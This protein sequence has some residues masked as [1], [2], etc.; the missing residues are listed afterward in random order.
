M[1]RIRRLLDQSHTSISFASTAWPAAGLVVVMSGALFA[2]QQE[3]PRPVSPSEPTKQEGQT[4]LPVRQ[5]R[6]PIPVTRAQPANRQPPT[7]PDPA[8]PVPSI[9]PRPVTQAEPSPARQAPIPV[10]REEPQANRSSGRRPVAMVGDRVAEGVEAEQVMQGIEETLREINEA[11]Q[12]MQSNSELEQLEQLVAQTQVLQDELLARQE[13]LRQ[14]LQNPYRR[15]A[16]EEVAWIITPE[17]RTAFERLGNERERQAFVDQFWLRRDPA[18]DTPD[19][20]AREEYYRRI[21][22]ANNEFG[23]SEAPGWQTIRGKT[24]IRY[25]EP[26]SVRFSDDGYERWF[27]DVLPDMEIVG[28]FEFRDELALILVDDD[29]LRENINLQVPGR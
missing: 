13:R 2:W 20:E 22:H 12:E 19:N 4:P 27:Y 1:F 23:S 10:T 8:R 14:E 17:E 24:Y 9:Q 16:D 15:W 26:S 28:G 6:Q 5:P 29:R 7:N 18:P 25:G 21:A 11:I 3:A